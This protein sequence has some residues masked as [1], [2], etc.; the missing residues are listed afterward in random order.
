MNSNKFTLPEYLTLALLGAMFLL[1]VTSLA[2]A[3]IV[4]PGAPGEPSRTLTAD[5]AT[6]IAVTSYSPADIIFLR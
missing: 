3:P 5:E 4:H 6:E 2:Q 1:P